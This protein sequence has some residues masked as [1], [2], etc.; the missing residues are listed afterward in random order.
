MFVCSG[1]GSDVLQQCVG[2]PAIPVCSTLAGALQLSAPGAGVL[3]HR[4]TCWGSSGN[5]SHLGH[6]ETT[7]HGHAGPTAAALTAGAA[8]KKCPAAP[9]SAGTD[10]LRVGV[11]S[12]LLYQLRCTSWAIYQEHL[13][14]Y[15]CK[16]LSYQPVVWSSGKFHVK[17]LN[18]G[19]I[20]DLSDSTVACL[21]VPDLSIYIGVNLLV[22]SHTT[23]FRVY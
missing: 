15:S 1:V 5:G 12:C 19:K 9:T 4:A 11:L 14:N 17:C 18:G 13:H 8:Q 7:A 2:S 6:P 10:V 3:W 22:F 20:S 16:Q 23:V 21:L